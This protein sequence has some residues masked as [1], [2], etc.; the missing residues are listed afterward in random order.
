MGQVRKVFLRSLDLFLGAVM[1][2]KR[3]KEKQ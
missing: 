3:T 2:L 1:A